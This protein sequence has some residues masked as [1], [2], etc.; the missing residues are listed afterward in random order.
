ML[1]FWR[2]KAD[3]EPESSAQTAV[4]SETPVEV[5]ASTPAA[6]VPEENPS[7]DPPAAQPEP[8]TPPEPKMPRTVIWGK[9]LHWMLSLSW[10]AR[11][12][13]AHRQLCIH[14]ECVDG[15]LLQLI[16]AASASALG[17]PCQ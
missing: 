14:S 8:E 9:I 17:T 5:E 4:E 15:A 11:V 13:N 16:A 12:S 2:V 3:S 10:R 6:P 7:L 1:G